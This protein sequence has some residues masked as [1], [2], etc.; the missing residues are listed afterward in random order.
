V[1]H[2]SRRCERRPDGE[3][4]GDESQRAGKE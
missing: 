4:H 2:R 3:Q 1:R